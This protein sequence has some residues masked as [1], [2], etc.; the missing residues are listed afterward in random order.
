MRKKFFHIFGLLL[1]A[2]LPAFGIER[3]AF[4]FT[5]YDLDVRIERSQ[6]R[7]GVRGHITL[8]N[9]SNAPQTIAALQISST[10]DWRSIRCEDKQLQFVSQPYTSDVDHTGSLSE[11]I[12]TLPRELKP[13]ES[14]EIEVGYEGT[15][16]LDATR[17]T[18][19]G[20]PEAKARNSDWDQ[21]A[22]AF[23]AVRGVGYVAWYPIAVESASL[24]QGNSVFDAVARW[25]A[26]EA[27]AEMKVKLS[28]FGDSVNGPPAT[29]IL[30]NDGPGSTEARMSR[31]YA[32]WSNC[33]YAPIGITV[34]SFVM[35]G[36]DM[37]ER[38]AARFFFFPS[39]RD[40]V[41]GYEAAADQVLPLITDW[42]GEPKGK[43][44]VLELPDA[45]SAPFETGGMTFMP[46]TNPDRGLARITLAHG[47]THAAFSS[48]RPWVSEGIAHFMQA[49]ER[50]QLAGR[51]A[52]LDYM[53]LHR[54][55]FLVAEQAVVGSKAGDGAAPQPLISTF[56]ESY[57]RSKAM[58]VWWML[59]DLIGEPALKKAI[60]K[61]RADEDDNPKYVE[62]L[63]EAESKA[64]LAWF[65][66][67]WVYQDKGLPDFR[68]E[69][70]FPRKT[71][72]GSYLVTVTIVNEGMA[73][74]MVPFTVSF[75]GGEI[76]QRI[77]VRGKAKAITRVEVGGR[78]QQVVVNDGS[79]P[80]S[81]LM[82][83]TFTI[84]SQ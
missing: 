13:K 37:H 34:P 51:K 23:T 36:Y 63:L 7:L 18:R 65:F 68:V 84:S 38:G 56:D 52:A 28:E 33:S 32:T 79:V 49:L 46:M 66:E 5:R 82:N 3:E 41:A 57:Y 14:I 6:Q 25:K 80:E 4:T 55:A 44:N 73:G 31:A 71:D 26:R 62:S 39:H 20:T 54:A 67:D 21:I 76:E 10:L 42:F 17:L 8:R 12:V 19:I 74:A 81:D 61:Y 15:I 59:R 11:A 78:P 50:E 22:S 29:E 75:E 70:A 83:N 1:L 9:D 77:E 53:G 72:K 35:A 64:D 69:S 48:S 2:T 30:C 45:G 16:P 60:R 58:Y 47:I 43:A 27:A 40:E 24:S